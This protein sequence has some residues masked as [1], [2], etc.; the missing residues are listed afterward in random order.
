MQVVR[1]FLADTRDMILDGLARAGLLRGG[2]IWWRERMRRRMEA[3]GGDAENIR[4]SV[5]SKHRMCRECRALVP[6]R[7]RVCPECGAP[8][9]G[10][11]RGGAGRLLRVMAPSFGSASSS[12]LGAL[13]VIYAAAAIGFPGSSIW[14][15]SGAVLER[16]GAMDPRYILYGHEW[17]RLL[18]A[19]FLHG[20]LLHIGFNGYALANI[21]PALEQ[22]IGSRRV[23]VLFVAT[24]VVSF[25]VSMA[26]AFFAFRVSVGASGA[27]FGMIG[28]G[29][30]HGRIRGGTMYRAF[31]D[32]LMRWAVFGL[33]LSLVPGVDMAAHAGGFVSGAIAGL[34]IGR[35]GVVRPAVDR[36]WTAAA[37]VA[38]ILPIAAFALQIAS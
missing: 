24:G 15:L 23:L 25:A 8:M 1:R 31:S 33:L 6:V 12:L 17:W 37:I 14:A 18:T 34:F 38:V 16:L 9:A 10:I 28:Y 5:A 36:L 32:N 19:V 2:A 30:V 27:I 35:S 11:P 26:A 4:R 7:E 13:I 20:S 29:V 3:L 22:A 21:G